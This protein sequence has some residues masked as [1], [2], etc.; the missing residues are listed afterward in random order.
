MF[1][2]NRKIFLL[3]LYVLCI[4]KLFLWTQIP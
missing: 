4:N 1:A 3:I 2:A